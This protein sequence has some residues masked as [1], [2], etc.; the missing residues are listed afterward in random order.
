MRVPIS[1]DNRHVCLVQ[2]C[3]YVP[4]FPGKLLI[5]GGC[6]LYAGA[7]YSSE[8]AVLLCPSITNSDHCALLVTLLLFPRFI[9]VIC[10]F[11]DKYML[12]R[13]RLCSCCPGSGTNSGTCQYSSSRNK[14]PF[15]H[16]E[17]N[18]S[19]LKKAQGQGS[20]LPSASRWSR[21]QKL[22]TKVSMSFRLYGLTTRELHEAP[23]ILSMK[24]NEL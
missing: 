18:L 12:F 9:P 14:W 13:L 23:V 5:L 10:S 8:N 2:G 1:T 4:F 16:I 20:L 22:K 17:E 6:G 24:N 21:A 11:S 7:T 15:G 19:I 3:D